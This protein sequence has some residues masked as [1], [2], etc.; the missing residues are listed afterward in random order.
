VVSETETPESLAKAVIGLADNPAKYDA[1]RTAAWQRS[2]EF[3]WEQVLRP[4]CDWLE[5]MARGE[6]AT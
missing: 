1:M 4:T 3:R 6:T 2:F 5:N